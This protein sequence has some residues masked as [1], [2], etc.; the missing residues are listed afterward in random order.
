M[1]LPNFC[2]D[3]THSVK[4]GSERFCYSP[5]LTKQDPVTGSRAVF[6][7]VLRKSRTLDPVRSCTGYKPNLIARL[8]EVFQ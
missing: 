2:V 5:L 7:D 4:Q 3:C 1:S 6:C 8:K